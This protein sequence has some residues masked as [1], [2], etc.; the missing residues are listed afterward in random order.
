MPTQEILYRNTAKTI[1]G[2]CPRCLERG[3]ESKLY[4][5]AGTAKD[6]TPYEF[7]YCELIE[8]C[9]HKETTLKGKLIEPIQCPKC[10]S[11]TRP[12]FKKNGQHYFV[13]ECCNAWHLADESF[14]LVMPPSCRDH[15]IPMV[16]TSKKDESAH[17]WKC[18]AEDC[19]ITIDSNKFG[20]I[21][22][23]PEESN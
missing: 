9:G 1:V 13:C 2:D 18:T 15:D 11:I 19:R 21:T 22:Y 8:D 17:Y 6:G 16:H 7:A 23:K 12:I 5:R 3:Y 14:N 10:Q 20:K 4:L